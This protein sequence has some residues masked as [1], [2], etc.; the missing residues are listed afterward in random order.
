MPVVTDEPR[1]KGGLALGDY[2][3]V[4]DRIKM[5][6][7][8][9]P[10][11][12]LVTDRVEIWQDDGVPR[13]VVKALAYR[14]PDDRHPAVGWS[15]MVL[16]GT[17]PYTRGSELENTETS[18][19]GRA[20]AALGIGIEKSIGS[21][22]EIDAKAG[23]TDREDAPTDGS[24]I[25]VVQR[26]KAPA[27][28]ELRYEP[29]G[30][31]YTGFALAQGRTRLQ[32]VTVSPL[33]E[34]LQPLLTGLVGQRVTVWGTVERVPWRKDGKDMPPY[35][36]LQLERIQTTDWTLP[37]PLSESEPISDEEAAAILALEKAEAESV[38]MGLV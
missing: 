35:Q 23:Q 10:D 3:E 14:T 20:F 34:V 25:G 38:G 22:N 19:W 21:K 29:D 18:A 4:K 30:R 1:S 9:Y 11:G 27:D 37:A 28:L 13:I 15:W 32:V 17:T 12:R 26:G 31:S 7:A 6:L 24:L 16:P 8:Q 2:V 33:A 5:F 36:R